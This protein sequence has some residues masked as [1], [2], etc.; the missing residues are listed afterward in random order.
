MPPGTLWQYVIADMP[1]KKKKPAAVTLSI[2]LK[3]AVVERIDGMAE[4]LG[5]TGSALIAVAAQ[6]YISR[7]RA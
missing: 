1:V 3:S 2:S 5:L 6:D 7:T 4:E